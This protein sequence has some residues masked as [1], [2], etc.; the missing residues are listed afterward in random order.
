MALSGHSAIVTGGASGLGAATARALY[1][2]GATVVVCDLPDTHGPRVAVELGPRATFAAVDVRDEGQVADAVATASGLAPLRAAVC[3]AGIAPAARIAGRHGPHPLALFREVV[4]V[5]LTGT[6]NTLRL[7]AA[8]MADGA[9][10]GDG[11]RGVI[12]M[13]SSVAAYEGQIGQAAYSASKG[14]VASL[15][16]TA[17]RDLAGR[18]IRVMAVAPGPMSTPMVAGFSDE[19]R[20]S[21]TRQ[22]VHPPRLGLPEEFAALVLHIVRNPYLNGEVIRLDAAGRMPPR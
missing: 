4:D 16:L 14:G 2:A 7:A 15:T 13:T 17:A 20:E 3:C 5:N 10:D 6:F 22:A 9:P 12:V 19:V 21:L 18:G 8:A 11:T 1:D